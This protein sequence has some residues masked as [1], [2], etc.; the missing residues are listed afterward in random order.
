MLKLRKS[1][2]SSFF[3]MQWNEDAS[4]RKLPLEAPGNAAE[5]QNPV[6]LLSMFVTWTQNEKPSSSNPYVPIPATE[7]SKIPQ[8]RNPAKPI[9]S[10]SP[11]K[12]EDRIEPLTSAGQKSEDRSVVTLGVPRIAVSHLNHPSGSPEG[13]PPTPVVRIPGDA[14]HVAHHYIPPPGGLSDLDRN[15]RVVALHMLPLV[16]LGGLIDDPDGGDVGNY[17]S[18]VKK[19]GVHHGLTNRRGMHPIK[20]DRDAYVDLLAHGVIERWPEIVLEACG[21]R[22]HDLLGIAGLDAEGLVLKSLEIQR[23]QPPVRRGIQD[24]FHRLIDSGQ[25]PAR[26]VVRAWDR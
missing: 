11:S 3:L 21:M 23:M 12:L 25:L 1:C 14:S 26:E 6:A 13:R 22:N 4:N 10:L 2:I 5:A 19:G 9:V 15:E 20:P 16:T 7:S 18:S 24:A 8:A 17:S